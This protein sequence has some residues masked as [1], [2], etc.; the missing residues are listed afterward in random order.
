MQL[1]IAR[2]PMC[3]DEVPYVVRDPSNEALIREEY[4]RTV[5]SLGLWVLH[6]CN[7]SRSTKS[8]RWSR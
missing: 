1:K 5:I 3:D 6:E 8:E 4:P 7:G 2:C